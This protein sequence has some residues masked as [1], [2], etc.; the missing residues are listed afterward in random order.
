MKINLAQN[1][2]EQGLTGSITIEIKQEER[3]AWITAG[4]EDYR[5]K[6]PG[7]GKVGKGTFYYEDGVIVT[8]FDV[9][10][11]Y[12]MELSQFHKIIKGT[13]EATSSS[14]P[15]SGSGAHRA[16]GTMID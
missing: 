10:L 3:C 13:L 11:K 8:D 14:K 9:G 7:A 6:V 16:M 1:L 4:D 2:K 12:T 5:V 15:V